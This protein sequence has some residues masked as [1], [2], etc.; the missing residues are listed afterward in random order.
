M[1]WIALLLVLFV[2][3]AYG[4][5][6][7]LVNC[8][9][10]N[11]KPLPPKVCETLRRVEKEQAAKR[12]KEEADRAAGVERERE[13]KARQQAQLEEQQRQSAERREKE[14][15]EQ[16]AR[17]EKWERQRAEDEKEDRRQAKIAAD[18]KKAKMDEC[19]N[20]YATPSIGM[21]LERAN[22]CVA[23]FKLVSQLNRADGV[24]STYSA[25]RIRI[26]VMGGKIAAWNRY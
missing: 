15:A 22:R 7:D 5:K 16:R 25:G 11:G 19:G 2:P 9:W 26:H 6:E 24:V 23:T 14:A 10:E 4:S 17:L 3:V 21:T 8:R 13:H 1:K 20:D 18:K 12:A